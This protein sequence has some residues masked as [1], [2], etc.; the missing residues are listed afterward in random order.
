MNAR[1]WYA[2]NARQLLETRRQGLAPDGRVVVSLVGGSF[3]DVA[4][5]TL[6]AKPD[7]P[8]DRLDWRMLVNLDV[9]LWAG[10]NAALDWLLTTASRIAQVRPK[11]LLLRFEEPDGIHDVEV[12]SGLHIPAVRHLAAQHAFDW[13]PI[14]C[15]GSLVG[16][17]L[18]AALIATHKPWTRL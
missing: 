12:G 7:M 15:S 3:G 2:T 6:Y 13:V 1:P 11:E 16:A 5:T 9:W 8:V 4:A 14:N 10:P 17:K 18:R